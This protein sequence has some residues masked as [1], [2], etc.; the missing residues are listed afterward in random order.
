MNTR[1]KIHPKK[2]RLQRYQLAIAHMKEHPLLYTE[3]A[4]GICFALSEGDI[5]NEFY[6]DSIMSQYPE[7]AVFKPEELEHFPFWFP[8]FSATGY[9]QR[10]E[11]LE[12]AVEAAQPKKRIR[13]GK[14]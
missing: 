8:T 5:T 11:T 4:H 13:N 2:V 14:R 9:N 3:Q 1:P 7:L 10:I 12:K 6:P